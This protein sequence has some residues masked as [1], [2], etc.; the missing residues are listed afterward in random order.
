[1][2]PPAKPAEFPEI[3][4][5]VMPRVPRLKIPPPL[6]SGYV[7]PPAI[8][9]EMVRPEMLT[10]L[11]ALTVKIR[12]FGVALQVAVAGLPQGLVSPGVHTAPLSEQIPAGRRTV[13]TFAPGPLIVT[14]SARL[15]RA[16]KSKIAPV[17]PESKLMVSATPA[18][19]LASRMAWRK[20]PEPLSFVFVTVNVAA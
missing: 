12:K 11:P 7:L 2:P 9:P 10:V 6:L 1:M 16:L 4:L 5:S 20:V 15:G 18:F 19:A 14:S 3:V 8:P 13:S 17:T